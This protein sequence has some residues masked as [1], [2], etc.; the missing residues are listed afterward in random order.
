MF[1]DAEHI[2][3]RLAA[4]SRRLRWHIM[5]IYRNRNLIIH[6]GENMQYLNA[7]VDNLHFY[8]DMTLDFIWQKLFD[9]FQT[10]D[11]ILTYAIALE[12]KRLTLLGCEF[13]KNGKIDRKKLKALDKDLLK[14]I[15]IDHSFIREMEI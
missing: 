15:I 4:H 12:G 5:R 2:Y 1:A 7:L 14:Q 11:S 9:G 6:E 3:D 10:I 13:D 8:V